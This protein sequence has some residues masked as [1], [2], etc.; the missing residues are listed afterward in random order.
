M[1]DD[2]QPVAGHGDTEHQVREALLSAHRELLM[3]SR[4]EWLAQLLADPAVSG[5]AGDGIRRA[6][7][8]EAARIASARIEADLQGSLLAMKLTSG[9]QRLA[10]LK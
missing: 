4:R 8:D 7:G 9:G 10:R 5:A 2:W 1:N 3:E 6:I